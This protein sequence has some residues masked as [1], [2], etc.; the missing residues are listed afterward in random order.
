MQNRSADEEPARQP[1]VAPIA[2]NGPGAWQYRIGVADIT[3]RDAVEALRRLAYRGAVQFEWNDATTLDWS[4]AAETG[5]VLAAWDADGAL[6]STLRASVFDHAAQAEAFLEYSLEG[7]DVPAPMLV[8]SRAATA[9]GAARGGLFALLR[10]AYL[11]ALPSTP[12]RSVAAIVYEGA[13]HSLSM[14][15]CGYEFFEPCA[16][17][18]TEARARTRPLLAVLAQARFAHSLQ[19]RAAALAGKT[20]DVLIDVAAIAAALN[21]QCAANGPGPAR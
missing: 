10:Y 21:A 9:P 19:A 14:R 18:D 20:A 6:L 4:A 5:A 17:W 3:Q 12:V 7:I 11:S 16:G 1:S 15:D 13:G 8:L 2:P